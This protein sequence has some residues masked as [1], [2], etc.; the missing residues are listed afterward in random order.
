MA[1]TTPTGSTT[2]TTSTTELRGTGGPQAIARDVADNVFGAAGEA[3]AR[4]P[5]A[6]ATTRETLAEANRT[7]QA[8]STESLTAGALLSAGSALGLFLGGA[9]R[10]LVL[11]ALIPAAAMALVVLDRQNSLGAKRR[12]S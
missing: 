11:L 12:T 3:V 5:D 4:I 6:A 2:S 10:F 9:N 1:T 7:L 8:G